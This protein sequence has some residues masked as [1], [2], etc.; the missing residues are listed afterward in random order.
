MGDLYETDLV[1]WSMEQAQAIRAAA[2]D[3]ANAPVDWDHVAEEIESLGIAERRALASLIGTVIEHLLKLQASPANDPVRLWRESVRRA[4][5]RIDRLLR[6]SPSLRRELPAII[7]EETVA[8]RTLVRE[9]LADYGETPLRPLDTLVFDE[10][11]LLGD[12]LPER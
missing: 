10:V 7:A 9:T 5:R 4:R 12:W 1:A 11:T 6:D 8:A 2:R 3:G